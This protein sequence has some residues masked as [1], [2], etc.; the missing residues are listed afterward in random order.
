[1]RVRVIVFNSRYNKKKYWSNRNDNSKSNKTSNNFMNRHNII[2]SSKTSRNNIN[3]DRELQ[4]FQ[5]AGHQTRRCLFYQAQ[6]YVLEQI[7][8]EA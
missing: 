2:N 4:S 7:T 8:S 5:V 3:K 1:M 6:K